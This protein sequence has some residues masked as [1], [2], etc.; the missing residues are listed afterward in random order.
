MNTEVISIL[1]GKSVADISHVIKQG[2]QNTRPFMTGCLIYTDDV[3]SICDGMVV[4]IGKDDKNNLYSV[5]VEYEDALYVRYCLLQTCNVSVGQEIGLSDKIGSTYKNVLRFE[6]CTNEFSVFPFRCG[7]NQ[8][9]KHDPLPV[10]IGEVTLPE[11]DEAE[12]MIITDG[13]E[14]V[15]DE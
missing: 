7:N 13:D 11:I 9:Y 6:Y 15:E 3:F 4:D 2:W 8:L 10:L 1:T 5:T 14:D 12:G